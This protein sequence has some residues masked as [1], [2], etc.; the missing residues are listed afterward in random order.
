MGR[1]KKSVEE[2]VETEVEEE[3][4]AFSVETGTVK[5]C[6]INLKG[7]KLYLPDGSIGEFDKEGVL[8]MSAENAQQ[9]LK[10]PG[11]TLM[12]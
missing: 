7:R 8:E 12:S 5:I 3:K 6:N 1:T 11:F 2:S 10:I 9:L 4:A